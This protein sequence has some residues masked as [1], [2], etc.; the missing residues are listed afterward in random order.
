MDDLISRAA[1]ELALIEKGQASKRYK[2]GE[3]WELNGKEI[4]EALDTV[5]VV[6]P[7]T[8]KWICDKVTERM[9]GLIS[10]KVYNCS[11]CGNQIV[12]KKPYNFCSNCGA[13]MEDNDD[14]D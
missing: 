3:F 11:E 4:R 8:G 1:A 13:R 12:V 9:A 10:Y 14:N 6:K 5:P 2:L 7:K